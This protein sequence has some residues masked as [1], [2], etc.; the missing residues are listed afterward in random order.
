MDDLLKVMS[1]SIQ[2]MALALE[3]IDKT[4]KR[5]AILN[6]VLTISLSITILG[7]VCVHT[8]TYFNSDYDYGQITQDQSISI[9]KGE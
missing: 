7:I 3:K 6:I 2:N 4:N 8:I 5:M 1:E 9:E